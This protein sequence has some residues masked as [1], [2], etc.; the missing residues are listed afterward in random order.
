M[1]RNEKTSNFSH[2]NL[3]ADDKN[4]AQLGVFISAEK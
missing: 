2:K 3:K 1:L 4:F